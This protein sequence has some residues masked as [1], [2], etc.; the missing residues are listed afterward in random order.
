M[1]AGEGE[2]GALSPQGKPSLPFSLAVQLPIRLYILKH[3]SAARL[4]DRPAHL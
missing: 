1:G 4:I 2:D 3:T